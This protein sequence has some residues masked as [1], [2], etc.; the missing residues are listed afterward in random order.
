MT[1]ASSADTFPHDYLRRAR[2]LGRLSH[3]YLFVGPD[4]VGKDRFALTFAKSLFCAADEPCETCSHCRR[5]EHGNHVGVSTYGPVEG[6]RVIDIDTVRAICERSH[7][8]RDHAFVAIVDGAHRMTVPAANALLKTLEEPA[9][10]FVVVLTAPS[11]GSLLPT[12]ISRCHR[13]IFASPVRDDERVATPAYDGLVERLGAS[14]FA[15]EDPRRLLGE[16]VPDAETQRERAGALLDECVRRTR[17]VVR[18]GARAAATAVA[19]DGGQ[20]AALDDAIEDQQCFLELGRALDGNVSADLVFEQI[21][22]RLLR[23]NGG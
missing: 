21:I 11:L 5:I 15:R 14:F 8:A 2:A 1:G 20:A 6:K 10:E 19:D 16:L 18:N 22:A 17:D 7:Y 12:I 23:R 9:G 3:A 4:Q 13:V